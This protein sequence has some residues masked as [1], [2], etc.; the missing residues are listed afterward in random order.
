MFNLFSVPVILILAYLVRPYRA[1]PAASTKDIVN[2]DD[3]SDTTMTGELEC[4]YVV[5]DIVPYRLLKIVLATLSLASYGA[6]EASFFSFFASCLQY[7]DGV[8]IS[9]GEAASILSIGS[10]TFTIGRGLAIILS[11]Y[12]SPDTLIS[13]HHAGALSA[14]A[15]L[16]FGHGN[17]QLIYVGTALLGISLSA[18]W[19][20]MLSFTE[21]HVRLTDRVCSAFS[22]NAGVLTLVMP[23][24]L[25]NSLDSNPIVLLY[26]LGGCSIVSII[27]FIVLKTLTLLAPRCKEEV[28]NIKF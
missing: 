10:L 17:L 7:L 16:F 2:D 13:V 27:S 22:F 5:K 19:S 8:N 24:L 15:L 28:K 4:N 18:I 20:G 25:A 3:V 23:F 1:T 12:F 14:L 6:L 11:F 26:V 9:A 21:R